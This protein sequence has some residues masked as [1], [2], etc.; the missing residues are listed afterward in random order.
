MAAESR[1][2]AYGTGAGQRAADG[3][4]RGWRLF[5]RFDSR[6]HGP[7]RLDIFLGAGLVVGLWALLPAVAP[8][9][10]SRG[11]ASGLVTQVT[12]WG[13]LFG[14]P[15]AFAAQGADGDREILNIVVALVLCALM[16]WFVIQRVEAGLKSNVLAAAGH[17][18]PGV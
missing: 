1:P 14:P 12:I 18:G 5:A 10:T 6:Y 2:V 11:A 4:R 15:A 9:P 7:A 3:T 8:T 17:G 13:V 16:L